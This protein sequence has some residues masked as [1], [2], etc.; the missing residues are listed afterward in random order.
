MQL[1]SSTSCPTATTTRS[2]P[3]LRLAHRTLGAGEENYYL[4]ILQTEPVEA[5]PSGYEL[6][7]DATLSDP[8]AEQEPNG[9]LDTATSMQPLSVAVTDWSYGCDR[10]PDSDFCRGWLAGRA[11][12]LPTVL[13]ADGRLAIDETADDEDYFAFAVPAGRRIALALSGEAAESGVLPELLRADGSVIARGERS[14]RYTAS[15][16]HWATLQYDTRT[17]GEFSVRIGVRAVPRAD[18]RRRCHASFSRRPRPIA[19][20]SP[21]LGEPP[22]SRTKPS[23]PQTTGLLLWTFPRKWEAR[24]S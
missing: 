16:I 7:L 20:S 14:E 11:T 1:Q 21:R 4:Q 8:F 6:Q 19:A 18:G 13:F 22:Y 15:G 10:E 5:G 3:S 17:G 2:T 24:S 9:S 12:P 23:T